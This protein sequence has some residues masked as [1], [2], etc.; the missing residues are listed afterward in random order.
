MERGVQHIVWT[1]CKRRKKKELR[2]LQTKIIECIRDEPR[3]NRT[4][5]TEYQVDLTFF[6][7]LLGF[8]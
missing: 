2:E 8:Y 4:V 6:I 3:F 1:D 5:K 7:S